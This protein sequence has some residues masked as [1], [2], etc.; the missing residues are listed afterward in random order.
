MFFNVELV[1]REWKNKSLPIFDSVPMGK[2]Q[3][4]ENPY[5]SILYTYSNS[6]WNN[7]VYLSSQ[8]LKV[9][10]FF[11]PRVSNSKVEKKKGL[12]NEFAIWKENFIFQLRVSNSETEK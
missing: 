1:T 4:I 2:L 9:K 12:L 5:S 6:K 7:L 8:L 10:F 11:E 3:V